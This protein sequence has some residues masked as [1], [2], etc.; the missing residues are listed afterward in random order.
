MLVLS[1][2]INQFSTKVVFWGS[3]PTQSSS[4]RAAVMWQ[5]S[6]FTALNKSLGD[7]KL[8][9]QFGIVIIKWCYSLL[10]IATICKTVDEMP[11]QAKWFMY[12]YKIN[13]GEFI[14]S[15]NYQVMPFTTWNSPLV[16]DTYT[17][18]YYLT[19]KC[20]DQINHQL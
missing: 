14:N 13:K 18:L 3:S 7:K 1:N 16:T 15:I 2:A 19:M 11:P 5:N 9:C 20:T 4:K 6:I 12:V 17:E 8:A 10:N